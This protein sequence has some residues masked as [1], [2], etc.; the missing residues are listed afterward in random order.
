MSNKANR[1]SLLFFFILLSVLIYPVGALAQKMPETRHFFVAKDG[2]DQHKGSKNSPFR[3]LSK[4]RD[5]IRQL[6]ESGEYPPGGIIVNIMEGE[7]RL[8]D[9]FTLN[10]LDGGNEQAKVVYR[11]FPGDEVWLTGG[12]KLDV[13]NF[14]KISDTDILQRLPENS[15]KWAY[16]YDL[17]KHGVKGYDQIVRTGMSQ[18]I[19]PVESRL[20]Y[21][22]KTMQLSRW[23]N[24]G[25][26]NPEKV[27]DKGAVPRY[28]DT[29]DRG[30]VFKY[31]NPRPES[32]EMNDDIWMFGY[33][34]WDWAEDR[35][36][37][38]NI[39]KEENYIEAGNAARYGIGERAR[40]Y[41][42]NILE[43]LDNPG[44]WY[45]DHK[46][47]V[48]YFYPPEIMNKKDKIE[49]SLSNHSII[50][51][52]HV[53]HIAIRGIKIEL[54][55]FHGIK[56]IGGQDIEITGNW[57][58]NMG[59]DAIHVSA[60]SRNLMIKNNEIRQIG[61]GGVISLRHSEIYNNHIHHF[62]QIWTT[63][64]PGIRVGGNCNITH[65]LIHNAPH[66]AIGSGGPNNKFRYN[67][68][69]SLNED[70]DDAGSVYEAVDSAKGTVFEFNYF[71]DIPYTGR[72]HGAYAIYLDKGRDNV[73]VFG[74]IFENIASAP[75][76]IHGGQYNDFH[77]NMI[78]SCKEA[79][80]LGPIVVRLP[81][82]FAKVYDNNVQYNVIYDS[83]EPYYRGFGTV[84]DPLELN[85][86]NHNYRVSHDVFVDPQKQDYRFRHADTLLFNGEFE[87]IDIGKIGLLKEFP[88]KMENDPLERI[89]LKTSNTGTDMSTIELLQGETVN[90]DIIGKTRTGLRYDL[91]EADAIKFSSDNE[92]IAVVNKKGTVEARNRGTTGILTVVQTEHRLCVKS[93]WISVK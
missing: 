8:K 11:A 93:I 3:S 5:A 45:I 69:Y 23:P 72:G 19:K 77:N 10:K 46:K 28:G 62:G 85:T 38:K 60:E 67:E 22:D 16:Q 31:N 71:H 88:W 59:G 50:K 37:V 65:N 82:D 48:L 51:L 54:G 57:I 21:N 80:K 4:A 63:S 29:T 87:A 2:S 81:A 32:W 35:L 83:G 27:L 56:V 89:F 18:P 34:I 86:I 47:G 42:F 91:S 84:G 74:N 53:S 9:G 30:G 24:E 79:F 68:I 17:K 92:N 1:K 73:R 52:N 14:K 13:E 76:F 7:Y 41:F 49:L 39:N 12:V 58:E 44:E 36:R 75:I 20:Y 66:S 40:Y 70:T 64:R 15:K 25:Y 26:L 90:I 61:G 33:W 78:I 43:E 6:K 55:Q